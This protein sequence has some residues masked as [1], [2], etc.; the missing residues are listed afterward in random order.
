MKKEGFEQLS[1]TH[2][3]IKCLLKVKYLKKCL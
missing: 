3:A 1:K 2:F